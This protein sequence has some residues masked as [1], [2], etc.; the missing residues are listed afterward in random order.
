MSHK[1]KIQAPKSMIE[2][3]RIWVQTQSGSWKEISQVNGDGHGAAF[4]S[5]FDNREKA[6]AAARRHYR[7]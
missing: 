5:A 6:I 1:I 3:W 7:A 2:G 4:Y